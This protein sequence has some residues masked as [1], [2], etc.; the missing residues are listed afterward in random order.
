MVTGDHPLTAHSIAKSLGLVLS[1]ARVN[2]DAGATNT[3]AVFA[4]TASLSCTESVQDTVT[5][6]KKAIRNLIIFFILFL[7]IIV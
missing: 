5:M 3:G 2:P 6:L 4:A 1:R 7:I